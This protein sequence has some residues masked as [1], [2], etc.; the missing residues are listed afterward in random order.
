MQRSQA[1]SSSH[2]VRVGADH[3][4][5]GRS[6]NTATA[7]ET[8]VE[9]ETVLAE[10]VNECIKC[11]EV[12]TAPQNQVTSETNKEVDCLEKQI[13]EIDDEIKR[14]EINDINYLGDLGGSQTAQKAT[15]RVE[16]IN[17][18]PIN[19]EGGFRPGSQVPSQISEHVTAHGQVV[20][21]NPK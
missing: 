11:D 10:K 20:G 3:V 18:D 21:K 7:V 12:N 13:K 17:A 4:V 16:I 6:D 5:E 19:N 2:G 1:H 9:V 15:T 14:Y 8:Q